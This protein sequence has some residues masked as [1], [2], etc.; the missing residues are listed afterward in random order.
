[1]L[2]PDTTIARLCLALAI[3]LLVGL[4]RG[5]RERAA[6]D[7]SRTAGIRTFGAISM[8]GGIAAALS[9]ATGSPSVLVAAMVLF[10]GL[11]GWFK[12]REA[13]HD[14]NFSVTGVVAAL[15][16]FALGALAVAGDVRLAAAGGAILAGLLA[17]REVLHGALLRL[18]WVE[19]RSAIVLALMTAVVLPLLPDRAIDPWGGFNPWQVWFFTVLTAAISFGGYVAVRLMGPARGLLVSGLAGAVV[20]STAVTVAFARTAQGATEIG[21]LAGAACLAATVSILRVMGI[22]LIV[23]PAILATAAPA[24]LSAAATFGLFGLAYLL[25]G[26][27]EAPPPPGAAQN[28]FELTTLL[29]FALM[30]AVVSTLSAAAAARFGEASLTGT[31]ALS[32]TFDVDVAV[33]SALRLLGQDI[34]AGAIGLAVLGALGANALGRLLLA[35]AAGPPAFWLRYL[36]ASAAAAV[37]GASAYLLPWPWG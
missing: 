27:A 33:L 5:W 34:S 36:A 12:A 1:M 13:R 23:Q 11:F 9:A 32:G 35:V 17:S 4:E 30:F 22:V 7:G 31:S 2:N 8:L 26:K 15:A 16:V 3:G 14:R 24:A 19:L 21:P 18:S 28:P 20:S 29:V 10:G 6:P 37:A 25:R